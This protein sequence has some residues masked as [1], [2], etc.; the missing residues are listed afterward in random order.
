MVSSDSDGERER[1]RVK[2]TNDRVY[3]GWNNR[4][5]VVITH[6]ISSIGGNNY[7]SMIMMVGGSSVCRLFPVLQPHSPGGGSPQTRMFRAWGQ[8]GSLGY[9]CLGDLGARHPIVSK[10]EENT[11]TSTSVTMTVASS[12]QRRVQAVFCSVGGEAVV[13]GGM[14]S[15]YSLSIDIGIEW[16]VDIYVHTASMFMN[17][18]M[19]MCGIVNV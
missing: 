2:K 8:V 4:P 6:L 3:S 18:C 12:V 13:H 10:A 16:Y 14:L 1:D 11:T 19:I 15:I 9:L 5:V 7:G 17:V